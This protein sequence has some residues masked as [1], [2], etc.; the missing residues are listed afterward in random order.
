[1][2]MVLASACGQT[3]PVATG[4]A[5]EPA[6]PWVLRFDASVG[7]A[8]GEK[9]QARYLTVTPETGEVTVAE[10]PAFAGGTSSGIARALL[11]DSTH[12]WALPDARPRAADRRAHRLTLYSLAD[13]STKPIDLGDV[14]PDYAVFNPAAPE[15]TVVDGGQSWRVSVEDG[16][17]SKLG[18]VQ[19]KEGWVYVGGFN[20]NTATPFTEAAGSFETDPPGNGLKD[21]ITL[22]RQGGQ[23]LPSATGRLE[24]LP[25]PG[26]ELVS[27]YTDAEGVS[28]AWCVT[29]ADLQLKKLTGSTW[30][31]YG[32]V[33]RGVVTD[34]VVEFDFVLPPLPGQ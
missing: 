5:P 29:G 19:P 6:R 9:L 23:V 7:G 34:A 28:W 2:V 15:L 26:C 21:T 8:D 18:T 32:K 20:V 22:E 3:A 12:Q 17:K 14:R 4:A 25:D 1:M 11:V 31:A 30:A 10:L 16:T 33:V 27:G 13:G 24:G